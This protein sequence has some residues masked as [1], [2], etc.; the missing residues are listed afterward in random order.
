MVAPSFMVIVLVQP[1][2]CLL[3]PSLTWSVTSSVPPFKIISEFARPVA[4]L[5]EFTDEESLVTL[6]LPPD[7]V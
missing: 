7:C 5:L 2:R 3:C 4:G 1:R 6:T